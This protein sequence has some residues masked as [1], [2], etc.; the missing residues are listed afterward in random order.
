M[1]NY[2]IQK[3]L[4]LPKSLYFNVKYFGLLNGLKLPIL[5]T[6]KV[7][8]R[9]CRGSIKILSPL[10]RGMILFG[11]T[12][13]PITTLKEYSLWNVEG[14]VIFKGNSTLGVGTK[15]SVGPKGKLFLGDKFEITANSTISCHNSVRIG[16]GCLFSWDILLI[17]T[18]GHPVYDSKK[19]LLNPDGKIEILDNVWVGCRCLIL[20]NTFI[21]KGSILAAGSLLNNKFDIPDS[22]IAGVPAIMKKSYITWESV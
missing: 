17:D 11:F 14:E 7:V 9:N 3:Y 22:L 13:T 8:L 6:Y 18:D 2:R 21:A 20:K 4:G 19:K 10:K 15:I 5:L 12:S 16:N 1:A